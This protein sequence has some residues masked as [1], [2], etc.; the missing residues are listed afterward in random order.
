MHVFLYVRATPS[1]WWSNV[2]ARCESTPDGF[3]VL[4]QVTA[5][6][7]P[8]REQEPPIWGKY[9]VLWL[10]QYWC[11]V[12]RFAESV[13]SNQDAEFA[14][15]AFIPNVGYCSARSTRGSRHVRSDA[16][17]KRSRWPQKLSRAVN[18]EFES[19]SKQD[20][21]LVNGWRL[22]SNMISKIS[23]G[24][25]SWFLDWVRNLVLRQL[26]VFSASAL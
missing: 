13:A 21:E 18:V 16:S 14:T 26:Q 6:W 20:G 5:V 22:G 12:R 2:L 3:D 4:A 11:Q 9:S 23:T 10:V 19:D 25:Q 24:M 17:S 15:L 8:R 7:L 1:N